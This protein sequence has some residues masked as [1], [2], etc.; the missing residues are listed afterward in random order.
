MAVRRPH[1]NGFTLLEVLIGAVL[2]NLFL[3]G[4]LLALLQLLH[5]SN[6]TENGAEKMLQDWNAVQQ[7]RNSR[8]L[9]QPFQVVPGGASGGITLHPGNGAGDDWEVIDE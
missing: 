3:L 7:L 5:L 4:F 1:Q 8:N 6:I 2:A 9:S